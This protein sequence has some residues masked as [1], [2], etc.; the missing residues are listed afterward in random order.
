MVADGFL[1]L[2]KLPKLSSCGVF[3]CVSGV[4]HIERVITQ[5]KVLL[6]LL[7]NKTG[8]FLFQSSWVSIFWII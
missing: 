6:F 7:S 5:K 1:S 2:L 4:K 3:N 8:L